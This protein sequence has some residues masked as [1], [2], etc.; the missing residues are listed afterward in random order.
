MQANVFDKSPAVT[1]IL[2]SRH[3]VNRSIKMPFSCSDKSALPPSK[4]ST[5][6]AVGEYVRL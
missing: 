2:F 1:N 3:C 4:L 6:V 5:L